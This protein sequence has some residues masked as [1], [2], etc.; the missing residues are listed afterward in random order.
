MKPVTW[1]GLF[2]GHRAC[3]LDAGARARALSI[4]FPLMALTLHHHRAA[5][6]G[7]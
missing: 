5:G 4:A 6:L 1:L 3:G 7:Y 2:S